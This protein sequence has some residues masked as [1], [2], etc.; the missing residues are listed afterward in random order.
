MSG[1]KRVSLGFGQLDAA[2]GAVRP[3]GSEDAICNWLIQAYWIKLRTSQRPGQRQTYIL[4][5]RGN[6]IAITLS[7]THALFVAKAILR[8]LAR[9]PWH[10]DGAEAAMLLG[11]LKTNPHKRNK[12]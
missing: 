10:R 6:P 8:D 12:R 4:G 9:H 5:D 2:A 1:K 11:I 3:V 7:P